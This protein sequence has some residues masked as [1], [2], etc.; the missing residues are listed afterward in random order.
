[1][2]SQQSLKDIFEADEEDKV[3]QFNKQLSSLRLSMPADMVHQ[4]SALDFVRRASRG[5]ARRYMPFMPSMRK[6]LI[7]FLVFLGI[8]AGSI[9]LGIRGY[10]KILYFQICN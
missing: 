4:M 6:R 2:P 5:K 8:V 1:M 7:F 9:D 10:V 3:P